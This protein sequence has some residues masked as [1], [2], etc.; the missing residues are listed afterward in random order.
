MPKIFTTRFAPSP[1]GELHLG[2]AYS[3]LLAFNAARKTG[4]RF[5]L[6]IED[7]DFGRCRPEYTQMLLEDLQ[8]L[9]IEWEEPIRIQSEH[10]HEY[11]QALERLRDM[12]VLYRCFKTRK[13]MEQAS[14][15][16]PHGFRDGIDGIRVPVRISQTEEQERLESGEAFAW[17]LSANMA[18]KVIGDKETYF[19][20]TIHGRQKIDPLL[21][22]DIIIARKDNMA[23]YHLCTVHDDA[24]QGINNIIRGEDLLIATH[25]QVVL[26]KLFGFETPIY[27]HHQLLTDENGM[28]LAKRD[29]SQTLRYL[30]ESGVNPAQIRKR[31]GIAM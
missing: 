25:I 22:G 30:R 17:R 23:S 26:Q 12:G 6:R 14:M 27:T 18:A 31:I 20:D 19:E 5:I 3:A 8:W 4:G 9:G 1:T 16:A 28:R 15:S 10:M 13:E 11:N 29:R 24:L 21:N 2:H 7:T